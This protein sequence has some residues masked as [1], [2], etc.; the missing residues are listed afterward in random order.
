[1]PATALDPRTAL[2]VIDLQRGLSAYPT[3]HPFAG[4]VANTVRLA[5]A[6]R[7]A[8]LP[9]VLVTVGFASD[10]A[11]AVRTRT[12]AGPRPI[13]T[14]P[15]FSTVVPELGPKP[16]DLLVVKRQPNAFYGTDLDLQLRRRGVTGIVLTGVSTS[17]GVDST[18]RAAHE[19]AYNVTFAA[20][21]MTDL[22][23]ASHEHTL[24]KMFPRTGEVDSTDAILALMKRLVP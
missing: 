2:V 17:I 11:D 18:A 7:R 24:K 22:D 10:G 6:F 1:M 13:P 8:S 21:A 23:A 15:E 14:D 9:V 19:R 16:G 20:D 12:D 5:D 4:V 3:V